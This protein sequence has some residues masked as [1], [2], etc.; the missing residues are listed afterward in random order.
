MDKKLT[1]YKFLNLFRDIPESEFDV[2]S[3][4]CHIETFPTGTVLLQEG[5]VAK[6][7]FFVLDGILKITAWS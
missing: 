3:K 4:H 6:Q 5:K 7:L 1:L 2:I